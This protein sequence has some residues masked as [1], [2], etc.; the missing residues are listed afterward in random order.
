MKK[1]K[2][3]R[4]SNVSNNVNKQNK[5]YAKVNGGVFVFTKSITVGE[6]AKQLNVGAGDIIKKLFLKGK[7]V[8]INQ[9]L[10]D[11]TIGELCLEYG[12]DF[13]KEQIEASYENGILRI[14]LPKLKP[15]EKEAESKKIL[16]K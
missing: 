2:D 13:K 1:K 3:E 5:D 11:D 12:Y 16:I 7:M 10:D 9:Y 4:V 8:N 14:V 15:E 6:L